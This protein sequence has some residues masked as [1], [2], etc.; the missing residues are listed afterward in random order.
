MPTPV[1]RNFNAVKEAISECRQ[2]CFYSNI[3]DEMLLLLNLVSKSFQFGQKK[4]NGS[5]D[6]V[7]G[8]KDHEKCFEH[9]L[10][11][12]GVNFFQLNHGMKNISLQKTCSKD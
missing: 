9:Y 12:L 5:K 7:T 6:R 2:K 10:E 8:S 4:A 3:F 11:L 1:R